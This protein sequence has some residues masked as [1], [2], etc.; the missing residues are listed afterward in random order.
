MAFICVHWL[1]EW[2]EMHDIKNRQNNFVEVH[3]SPVSDDILRRL[4]N[5]PHKWEKVYKLITYIILRI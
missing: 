3:M 5:N 4:L 2:S 1:P